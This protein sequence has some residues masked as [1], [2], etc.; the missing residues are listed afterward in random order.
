MTRRPIIAKHDAQLYRPQKRHVVSLPD[1]TP[2]KLPLKSRKIRIINHFK[3]TMFGLQ[4]AVIRE[5]DRGLLFLLI[6]VFMACGAISYFNLPFEPDGLRLL[7]YFALIVGLLY[8]SRHYRFF[9]YI[10]C[11]CLCVTLGIISAKFETWRLDTPMLGADV[12]THLTGRIL[13]LEW[14]PSGQ[15]KLLVDVLDT[16]KPKLYYGP[17]RVT[18]SV[19]H[20]PEDMRLG[21]GI[22]GYVRLRAESGPVRPD[23]YDF[24][25]FSYFQS[26]GAQGFVLGNL[27][28]INVGE[29]KTIVERLG[30]N[31]AHL[32]MTMTKRITDAIGGETG[33]VA[34]ALI[35][36]QRGGISQA[37]NDALR[38]AGLAHILSISGL[39]MAMV[40]G[41]VLLII[42][43]ILAFFPLFSSHY[44]SKKIA[45]IIALFVAAFY[46]MLSGAD[47]AAQRSFVMVAV[48]LL[49]VLFN[50]SAITMRN[51]AISGLITLAIVPHEILGPSFQMS[52]S[53]TAALVAVF[54][55]WSRRNRRVATAPQFVGV[56]VIRFLLLPIISTAVASL[57][58][59]T[60]SGIYAS[61]HF[62]NAAPLGVLSNAIAFPIMS[63][64]VMPFA[65]L[66]A[67]A[68]PFGLEWLPLQVMGYGV[69]LVEKIAYGIASISPDINPGYI[70]PRALCFLSIGLVVLL[71]FQTRL[72]LLS[73]IAFGAGITLCFLKPQPLIIIAED[74]KTMGIIDRGNLYL[75]NSKMSNYTINVWKRS[76]GLKDVITPASEAIEQ[77]QQFVCSDL[78]CTSKIKQGKQ[79]SI[80]MYKKKM[81][82]SFYACPFADLT[83]VPSKI[84]FATD[85]NMT[86]SQQKITARQLALYGSVMITDNNDTVWSIPNGPVRPWN[87]H[88][89]FL[90]SARE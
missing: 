77:G 22:H 6:P 4:N 65:L 58:A 30:L 17:K 64:L 38:V 82:D 56:S 33:S 41:M 57:V 52:F 85:C 8:L 11:V 89:K 67:I 20:L 69:D 10:G 31:I 86:T 74:A 71:F 5:T 37:T 36:G 88:R 42:R 29:P 78:V 19:R 48:M 84:Y 80:L 28:R 53:A 34:A 15:S 75:S 39:H 61:Y 40:S 21:D 62:S 70:P 7:A 68:M 18:L 26:I 79:V 44:S 2:F 90:R 45:A 72:R 43:T 35:T 23:G 25:F 60:A 55:W 46:L 16:E 54:G 50:R 3:T 9:W 87:R 27:D 12:S 59:G 14:V 24:G 66:A 51:L 32:R 73:I 1:N 13:S 47:V 49:A 76:Y 81:E 83:V 63:F